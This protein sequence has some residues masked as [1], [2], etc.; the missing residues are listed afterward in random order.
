MHGPFGLALTAVT[1]VLEATPAESMS[2]SAQVGRSTR[3]WV[4]WGLTPH[5]G[6]T[7]VDLSAELEQ[8]DAVDR[9]LLALRARTWFR[10]RFAAVI[11]RLGDRFS[12]LSDPATALS[13][14]S[15]AAADHQIGRAGGIL[16][17][18]PRGGR[19]GAARCAA[20][21]A[22]PSLFDVSESSSRSGSACMLIPRPRKAGKQGAERDVSGLAGHR[23]RSPG[24]WRARKSHCETPTPR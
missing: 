23:G 16:A 17:R 12:T 13:G 5:Y 11:R 22:R 14:L 15:A 1:R 18:A 24:R 9:L 21:V 7:W 3:A 20:R 8:A 19:R 6:G 4:R 2:G 10:R